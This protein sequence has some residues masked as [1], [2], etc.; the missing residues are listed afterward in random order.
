MLY[1]EEVSADDDAKLRMIP[2][3]VRSAIVHKLHSCRTA[4]RDHCEQ[5]SG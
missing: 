2:S 4:N 3:D 1:F 5:T